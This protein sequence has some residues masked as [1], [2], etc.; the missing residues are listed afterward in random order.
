MASQP[1]AGGDAGVAGQVV[2][3]HHDLARRV[4][5]LDQRKKTLIGTLL[6]DGAVQVTVWPSATRSPPYTQVFSDPRLY[7]SGALTRWPSADQPGAGGNVRGTTGPSSS[8]QTTVT[9]AGGWV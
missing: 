4:G 8:A 1:L 6:R 2:G 5:L 7:S 3:D 9:P